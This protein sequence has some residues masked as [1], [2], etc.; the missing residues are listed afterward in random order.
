[1]H[2]TALGW[3]LINPRMA[4]R[5]STEAMGETA[6]NVAERY[7]ISREDQDAFALR[8]HQ[9]A[10]AARDE[11]RFADEL[12]AVEAPE[13]GKASDPRSTLTR[14]RAPTP[15][16]SGW[17]SCAGVSR[18]RQRDRRQRL[19]PQRR[20]RLP[21]ARLRAKA[22]ELG[23]EPLADR[24]HRRRRRRPRAAWASARSPRSAGARRGR[25]RARRD[26]PDRDQRGVRRPGARLRCASS[27]S[28]RSA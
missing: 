17:P 12:V 5:Y 23:A 2:D 7:G 20:R 6:E 22:G 27:A 8:S 1:M 11:G 25:A 4:E 13:G 3:R 21:R 15:P 10:V 26:R 9:R 28:T 18:R 14:G 16:S 19:D 24:R